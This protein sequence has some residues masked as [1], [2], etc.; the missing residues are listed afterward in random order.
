MV[1]KFLWKVIFVLFLVGRLPKRARQADFPFASVWPSDSTHSEQQQGRRCQ[2]LEPFSRSA[3]RLFKEQPNWGILLRVLFFPIVKI[4]LVF[5]FY[6]FENCNLS[7]FTKPLLQTA[8]VPGIGGQFD[9]SSPKCVQLPKSTVSRALQK[10]NR[11][12]GGENISSVEN[13]RIFRMP[14]PVCLGI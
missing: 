3:A 11:F 10:Q 1:K 7:V 12:F 14:K 9:W 5:F 8:T 13:R 6:I 2:R 4:I